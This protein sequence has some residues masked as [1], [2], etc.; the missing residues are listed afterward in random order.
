[1]L[2]SERFTRVGEYGRSLTPDAKLPPATKAKLEQ[3]KVDFEHLD[4]AAWKQDNWDVVFIA[5]VV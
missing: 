5:C 3:R 4:Q 2:L 1:M